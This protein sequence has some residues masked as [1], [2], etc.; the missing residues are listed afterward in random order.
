MGRKG[1]GEGGELLGAGGVEESVEQLLVLAFEA[2][3]I[4]V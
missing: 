4:H 1:A 3:D 2:L